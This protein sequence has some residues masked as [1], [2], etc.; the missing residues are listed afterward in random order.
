MWSLTVRTDVDD[1]R[2]R[3]MSGG[4]LLCMAGVVVIFLPRKLSASRATKTELLKTFVRLDQGT[5]LAK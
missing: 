1:D 2:L 5:I 3:V 4:V